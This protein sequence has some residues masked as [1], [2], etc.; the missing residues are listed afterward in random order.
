MLIATAGH[1]DHG[2]TA[3]VR[4]LT[5]VETDR[6]PEEKA[7]GITIDLG[8]AYWRIDG[9]IIGFVDVPG[10]ERFIRNMLAGVTGVDMALIVVAADDGV[11]PQTIEHVQ[12]LDLLGASRAVVAITKC[13]KVGPA[14]I[15]S[16]H[17]QI[18]ALLDETGMRG[19][20]IFDVSAATGAGVAQLAAAL[21]ANAAAP[22]KR[23]DDQRGFRLAIDRS[24]SVAGAGTVVTG[25]VVDGTLNT[26]ERLR[27][28]PRGFD[29]RV[30]AIQSAAAPIKRVSAGERCA[31]NLTGAEVSQVRRGDWLVLPSMVQPT[32]RLEVRLR[33]LATR[34]TPLKHSTTVHLHIGAAAIQARVLIAKQ[35]SIPPGGDAVVQFALETP[36][37]AISG[38]RFVIRDH[39][40]RSTIGGGR[41]IDPLANSDR[42]SRAKR[43]PVSAAFEAA[44]AKDALMAL[45]AIPNYEI[46]AQHFERCFNLTPTAAKDLYRSCNAL[47]LGDARNI[48]IPTAT[49]VAIEA[50]IAETLV[51]FHKAVPDAEAISAKDLRAKIAAEVSSQAFAALIKRLHAA[52]QVVSTGSLVRRFDHVPQLNAVDQAIWRKLLPWLEELGA[53]PFTPEELAQEAKTNDTTI[54]AMLH[55]KRA[56][57]EVWRIVNERHLLSR[58]VATLA[59]RAALL[60]HQMG[61]IGFTAAQYRDAIGTGRTWAIHILEFFDEIGVTRRKGDRRWVRADYA[62]IVGA[63]EPYTP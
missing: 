10:H 28:A 56:H 34:K 42:G 13:D 21:R 62:L 40:A 3:L 33:V 32:S 12:I 41:V 47:L 35:G 8:F 51:K 38:D 27:L 1:I 15:D 26:G 46:D 18:A 23:V 11:M 55:R 53:T 17:A 36:T 6:L 9:R 25:T 29:V 7:R 5:G 39:A 20:P 2:K 59:A 30:R 14:E 44:S 61:E 37:S 52:G 43:L 63:S 22:S 58:Q 57:G 49:A 4:A 16:A 50:D 60:S 19:V 48:A 45:L 24:F 54:A 31:L